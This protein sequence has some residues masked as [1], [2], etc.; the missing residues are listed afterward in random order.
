VPYGRDPGLSAG[1]DGSLSTKSEVKLLPMEVT[2]GALKLIRRETDGTYTTSA[3][4][5]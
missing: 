4:A 2:G 5:E 3:V 1:G